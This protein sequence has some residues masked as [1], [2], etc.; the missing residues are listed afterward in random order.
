MGDIIGMGASDVKR[1]FPCGAGAPGGD[2][3]VVPARVFFMGSRV[4]FPAILHIFL[5]DKPRFSC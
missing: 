3:P 1:Q 5:I 4:I 2:A